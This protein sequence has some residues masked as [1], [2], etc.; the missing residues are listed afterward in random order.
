MWVSLCL[1]DLLD[2]A[3]RQVVAS[4]LVFNPL[5]LSS[6]LIPSHRELLSFSYLESYN[7]TSIV[8]TLTECTH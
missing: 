6:Q 8:N 5:A 7:F 1:L 3:L 4:M 2:H